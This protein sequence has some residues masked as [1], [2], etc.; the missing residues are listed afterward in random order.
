MS[1]HPLNVIAAL[2]PSTFTILVK[3]CKVKNTPD[4]LPPATKIEQ[5]EASYTLTERV[6][7]LK[8]TKALHNAL[9]PGDLVLCWGMHGIFMGE[10]QEQNNPG[11]CKNID[12][13]ADFVY[14]WA[15]QKVDLGELF[16]LNSRDEWIADELHC[17]NINNKMEEVKR[18]YESLG[19]TIPAITD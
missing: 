4:G 13:D 2:D 1:Q 12:P 19:F 18:Q 15:F 9:L 6:F 10:V 16:M 8:A 3:I 11:L 5:V 14:S 7:V 17:K